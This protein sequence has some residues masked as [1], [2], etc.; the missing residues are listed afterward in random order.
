[1]NN[2]KIILIVLALLLVGGGVWFVARD[3]EEV[4]SGL[5][6]EANEEVL[7]P[8][9][10][11]KEDPVDEELG[12]DESVAE[13]DPN[14]DQ[15][16]GENNDRD[17]Q[18]AEEGEEVEAD[19]KAGSPAPDFTVESLDGQAV[20]LSD[21]MGKIV[22]LNFWAT[23]CT[24]CDQEMPD[25]DKLDK[26]FEDVEVLAVDVMEEKAIVEDYIEEGG[27]EFDVVLD[28]EGEIA[29]TYLVSGYPTSYFIEE[30]GTLIGRVVG[31]LE[32]DMMVDIIEQIK[33]E[34]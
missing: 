16:S 13:E 28:I 22:L 21:Y 14:D 23:W 30:D 31:P 25:L 27:Y 17:D 15:T 3:N 19:I 10:E 32:Y 12:E 7:D 11:N 33:A 8:E 24:F 2:Q 18:R 1:M 6:E 4:G 29:R 5:E 26:E 20:S 34:R 9:D